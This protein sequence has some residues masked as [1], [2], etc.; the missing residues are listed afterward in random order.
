M[1]VKRL[2]G[3]QLPKEGGVASF[4]VMSGFMARH[5]CPGATRRQ[6]V[7]AD[8]GSDHEDTGTL[9]MIMKSHTGLCVPA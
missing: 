5:V 8:D 6:A 3:S 1:K 7:T 4:L 9:C 2:S